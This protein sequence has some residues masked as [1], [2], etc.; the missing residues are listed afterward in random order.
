MQRI[1]QLGDPVVVA[2]H[3]QQVLGQ[4]VAADGD[5]ID[6][7]HQAID[8]IHRRWHFHHDA[9][10]RRSNRYPVFPQLHLGTT[11]QIQRLAQLADAAD[12]WKQ[13]RQIGIDRA[14]PQHRP[15]LR[16]EQVGLIQADA[17]AAPAQ[18]RILLTDG[19][20]RQRLVATHI[21]GAQHHRMRF[22]D[23]QHSGVDGGLLFLAGETI[24]QKEMQLR[25]IQPHALHPT[26]ASGGDIGEQA[27]I[28]MQF[29]AML[30]Q[31]LGRQIAQMLQATRQF[32]LLGN[33]LQIFLAQCRAGL[34]ANPYGVAIHRHLA[35]VQ[36]TRRQVADTEHRRNAQAAR[37]QGNVRGTGA[38]HRHQ[39]LQFLGR[40]IQQLGN[41]DLLAHQDGVIGIMAIDHLLL[42]QAVQQ[43][44]AKVED[45]GGTLAQ[46]GVVHF[47]ENIGVFQDRGPQRAGCPV[48]GDDP[49]Q[50]TVDQAVAAQQQSV[51]IEQRPIAGRQQQPHPLAQALQLGQLRRH[52]LAEARSLGLW[53]VDVLVRHPIQRGGRK[54]HHRL[55]DRQTTG[56]SHP[57]QK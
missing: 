23:S 12:H 16:L 14:G 54:H 27:G 31:G 57:L 32:G 43:A 41:A 50:G 15:Q 44:L 10:S 29:Q 51:S 17:D 37:Q 4:V 46:V 39:S 25:A 53:I 2:V 8:L 20:I 34:D 55:A 19:K 5:E 21:Q 24:A 11:Q 45:V 40:H 30:V 13:D 38:A 22:H 28:G 35:A 47:R 6:H 52:R 18:K 3:R 7:P 56:T 9:D 42:L 36:A 48:A 1:V 33:Q 49:L 26:V